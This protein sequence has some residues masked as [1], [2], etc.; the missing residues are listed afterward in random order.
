MNDVKGGSR[1]SSLPDGEADGSLEPLSSAGSS[2]VGDIKGHV[3]RPEEAIAS[4]RQ[5]TLGQRSQCKITI[6]WSVIFI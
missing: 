6:L 2:N 4:E 3:P 5:M 1:F